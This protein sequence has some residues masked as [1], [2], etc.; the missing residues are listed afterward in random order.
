MYY[1][2]FNTDRY[3][4]RIYLELAEIGVSS[5]NQ[6]KIGR[7]MGLMYNGTAYYDDPMPE[8]PAV[9]FPSNAFGNRLSAY[10]QQ[11]G[12]L[13][14][15]IEAWEAADFSK[16]M[17]GWESHTATRQRE[18]TGETSAN[19]TQKTT[20]NPLLTPNSQTSDGQER[21]ATGDTSETENETTTDKTERHDFTPEE[22]RKSID[23]YARASSPI[24][25]FANGFSMLLV[26]DWDLCGGCI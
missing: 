6:K 9:P 13:Q 19:E 26:F 8:K 4:G 10:I 24:V 18:T 25:A 23:G 22:H 1:A 5:E 17:T 20:F 14:N 16:D 12:G 21:D 11:W 2:P 15:A 3:I 7:V